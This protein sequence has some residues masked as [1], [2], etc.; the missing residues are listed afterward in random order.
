MEVDLG[1]EKVQIGGCEGFSKQ[2]R[3]RKLGVD[4]GG[5]KRQE[6]IVEIDDFSLAM[7]KEGEE[8]QPNLVQM[9]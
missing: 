9:P 2:Y 4:M 7:E 3:T 6:S 5:A 8:S 1:V